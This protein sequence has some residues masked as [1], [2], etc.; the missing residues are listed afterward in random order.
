VEVD[1]FA[2]QNEKEDFY[3][4]VSRLVPFKRVDLIIDAFNSMP[5][6]KLFILGDGP[7]MKKLQSMAGSN[8]NFLGFQN[9]AIVN[10]YLKKARALIFS[11][12]EPFGIAVVEAQ[13]C[14][15]P[16]IALGKGA[17]PEIIRDGETGL[18][19]H[20]QNSAALAETVNRFETIRQWFEPERSRA[21]AMRF[22]SESFR[23]QFKFFVEQAVTEYFSH[24]A[25]R[26][27]KH[28]ESHPEKFSAIAG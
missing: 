25:G 17:A 3:V 19:F 24:P 18:F 4:A 12:M 22:S 23:E 5:D 10:D 21:N 16:V 11:S 26:K 15:T 14:G 27:G 9:H 7:D 8:I 20:E 2:L 28:F 1:R 13:A 6:K